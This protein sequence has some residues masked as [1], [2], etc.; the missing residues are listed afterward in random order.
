MSNLVRQPSGQCRVDE[1]VKKK[2]SEFSP[3]C[4]AHARRK[5]LT[6]HPQGS[7]IPAAI[8]NPVMKEATL[9]VTK[10]RKALPIEAGIKW[11]RGWLTS[12]YDSGTP[13][14]DKDPQQI[15]DSLIHKHHEESIDPIRVLSTIS[16]FHYLYNHR[17]GA[18]LDDPHFKYQ[19]V[20]SLLTLTDL[21]ITKV[22]PVSGYLERTVRLELSPKIIASGYETLRI[23]CLMLAVKIAER[24]NESEHWQ[25][26]VLGRMTYPVPSHQPQE[27]VTHQS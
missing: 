16:A 27:G 1:C 4:H 2:R 10:N 19:L 15:V 6:G 26:S 18:F 17:D 21:P 3:Y 9:Y 8:I 20:K 24:L 5:R 25:P 13:W 12:G 7:R 11:C 14:K 23:E 22:V